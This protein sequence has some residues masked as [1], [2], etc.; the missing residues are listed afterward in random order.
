MKYAGALIVLAYL[1]QALTGYEPFSSEARGRVPEEYRSRPGTL[2]LW[3][4]GYQGGK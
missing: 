2:L 3:H 1:A 4:S